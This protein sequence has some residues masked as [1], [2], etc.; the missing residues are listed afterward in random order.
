MVM[1]AIGNAY[2]IYIVNE[3]HEKSAMGESKERI[4]TLAAKRLLIPITMSGLT[5]F[6]GFMSLVTASGLRAIIDFAVI[7]AI[8]VLLSFIFTLTFLPALLSLLPL[9]KKRFKSEASEK[10]S[11]FLR[12]FAG[13]IGARTSS[14]GSWPASST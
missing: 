3:Y 9:A 6:A 10:E 14:A 13:W 12:K 2:G 11:L 5:V 1:M 4:V 8:G 7:N